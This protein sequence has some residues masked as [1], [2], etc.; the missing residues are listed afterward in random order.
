M[1]SN[2]RDALFFNARQGEPDAIGELL[3]SYRNYLKLLASTQLRGRLSRRVSPSDVVQE[4][5]LAAHRDFDAFRGESAGQFT[6]WL[7]AIL[8][9][10]LLNAI[11]RHLCIKR[12]ARR[13]ISFEAIDHQLDASGVAMQTLLVA[14]DPTPSTHLRRDE[15]AR[16]VADLMSQ[17]PDDYRDVILLRNFNGLRFDRVAEQMDRSPVAARLLWLRAIR[18]LRELYEK[19]VGDESL[20]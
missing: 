7:R 13:E 8:S 3:E 10:N 15:D 4:T 19:E 20:C 14:P 1:D 17:L 12:D 5:M 11:D 6:A 16:R 2:E 18:K 9:H